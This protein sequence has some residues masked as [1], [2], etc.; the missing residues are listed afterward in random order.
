[1]S[2]TRGFLLVLHGENRKKTPTQTE[3]DMMTASM[4]T[5]KQTTEFCNGNQPRIELMEFL[6]ILH[7]M[8]VLVNKQPHLDMTRYKMKTNIQKRMET[9]E[10]TEEAQI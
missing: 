8:L 1:M 10:K 6:I 3:L 9:R 7:W 2:D 5:A 4:P